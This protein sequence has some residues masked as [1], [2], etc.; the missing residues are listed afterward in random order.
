MGFWSA[1]LLPL[2]LCLLLF[3]GFLTK[4]D[5]LAHLPGELLWLQ[6]AGAILGIMGLLLLPD[7]GC[8]P[9]KANCRDLVCQHG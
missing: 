2:L 8:F 3:F 1:I 4:S 7:P 6:F 9:E 5:K